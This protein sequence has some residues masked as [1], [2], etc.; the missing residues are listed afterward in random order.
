MSRMPTRA[1]WPFRL[2]IRLYPEDFRRDFGRDVEREFAVSLIEAQGRR[3]RLVA[4][5]KALADAL[6]SIPREHWD[7]WVG[8]DGRSW[9]MGGVWNDVTRAIRSLGR[10]PGFAAVVVLTVG[11]G[12]GA[13]ATIFSVVHGVLLA[14]LP[15]PDS[16]RIVLVNEQMVA[17]EQNVTLSYVNAQ[18]WKKAQTSL[19]A[20]ALLRGG[21]LTLT[22]SDGAEQLSALFVDGEYFDVL[23]ARPAMGRV[24]GVDENTA[25]GGHPIAILTHGAWQRVFGGDPE[26]VGA[27]VDLGGLPFTVIGVLEEDY[28]DPFPGANGTGNDVILPAMMAGQI[29]PRGDEVVR[30]RRW[31][32]FSAIGKLRPGVTAEEAEADLRQ[33]AARLE[34]VDPVNRGMSATVQPFVQATTQG[35]R[36]PVLTLMGGALVLLLIAC[37]NVANLLMVRGAARRQELAVQLALGAGRSRLFRFLTLESLVLAAAGGALGILATSFALP[38][39]LGLVPNQLPTTADVE[40]SLPV[41]LAAMGVTLLAGV[42]FGLLPAARVSG[43]DLRGALSGSRSVGD[44]RGDRVRNGLV[45]FEVATA[46]ILLASSALLIRSF[47]ELSSADSGFTT[48]NVM[49]FRVNLP[50]ARYAD[51]ASMASAAEQLAERL[52]GLPGVTFAQPWGPGRPGLVFNFQTS[53]PDEMVVDQMGDAP[54]ARRHHVLPG[55]V[56]DMGLTLLRGRMIQD[57]DVAE[58]PQVVV[59]SESM[60]N[61]LWPGQDAIGR[62]YHSFQ[63]PGAP[64]PRNR[65]W[66]VVGVVSDANHGGRVPIPGAITTSNDSYFPLA[67]RPERAFTMLVQTTQDPDMAPIREAVRRFDP[68]IPVFQVATIQDNFRQEE[69]TSRFAAQLMGAFGLAALL[70]SALGVYG[71]ISFTVSQRTREIG[72]RAALGAEPGDT[73]GHFVRYGLKLAGAGVV[74]GALTAFGAAQGLQAVVPNVPDMDAVAV[75][76]AGG[77][78]VAVALLACLLPAVRATRIAPV[79][80]LKEE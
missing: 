78:L 72:L 55:G 69:G 66:T 20:L 43:G 59:I 50:P 17:T 46:T 1:P 9:D 13:T 57:T 27:S 49:T 77:L 47:Q 68:S 63:P 21:A 16:D 52:E 58:A 70:L 12:V 51:D 74:L 24:F 37:F 26:V 5:R 73:L 28:R 29:D 76:I 75:G 54:L 2:L 3:E 8:W 41:L 19:E 30:V 61:E 11:L 65:H 10:S 64:L 80:A 15:Y 6:I 60:A 4:W 38:S 32:T 71:V 34:E 53:I 45:L 18:D 56:E 42:A 48:E 39:L 33:I 25:P 23:G 40:L 7:T 14:P 31:R 36:G 62:Q 67:Q 22:R 79:I 35:L 44:P